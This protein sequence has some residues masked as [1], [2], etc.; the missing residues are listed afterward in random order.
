MIRVV[1]SPEGKVFLDHSQKANGRGAYLCRDKKCIEN[2]KKKNRLKQA[3]KVSIDE[4]FY[5]ELFHDV[6]E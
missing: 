4:Q 1:R 2:A 6:E 3:L 5:E